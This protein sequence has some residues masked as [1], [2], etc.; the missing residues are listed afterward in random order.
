MSYNFTKLIAFSPI[1][2]DN[3]TIW[4]YSNTADTI[5]TIQTTGYFAPSDDTQ[6][7]ASLIK[8]GDA[9]YLLGSNGTAWVSVTAVDPVVVANVV[10]PSEPAPSFTAS[11]V[12]QIDEWNGSGAV[13]TVPYNHTVIDIGGGFSA[14]TSAFTAPKDG[15][16]LFC[17]NVQLLG[18][19]A[20]N[21]DAYG[22]LETEEIGN[23]NLFD[24]P[25]NLAGT[26]NIALGGSV[27]IPRL[28][29]QVCII[30]MAVGG[31]SSNVALDGDNYYT[32]FSGSYL[33]SIA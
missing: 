5:T 30:S 13:L 24:T 28:A 29:G 8:V 12:G 6:N 31:I 11:R 26:T 33:S 10:A 3:S 14:I 7:L 9:M 4:H 2:A 32:T 18:V 27:I 1:V 19:D 22:Y 20:T 16:Y 15:M 17:A 21:T 23:F 25:L